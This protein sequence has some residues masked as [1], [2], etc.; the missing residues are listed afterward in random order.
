MNYEVSQ[1]FFFDAAHTLERDIE[2]DFQG[3]LTRAIRDL[4]DAPL[5]SVADA[6][7][8]VRGTVREY[9]R[10]SGIRSPENVLLETGIYLEVEAS[11]WRRGADKPERGP[12]R[13][14]TWVGFV[15]DPTGENERLARL[16]A[17]KHVAEELV[18]DLFTPVH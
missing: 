1:R 18:L 2:R 15:I 16:R 11:L 5:G 4:T 14:S 9:H 7:A 3:E 6:D 10:R 12:Y 13:P 17:M 8:I